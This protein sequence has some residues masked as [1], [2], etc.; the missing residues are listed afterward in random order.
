[1]EQARGLGGILN[2][3]F[4]CSYLS[5][6]LILVTEVTYLQKQSMDH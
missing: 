6:S 3:W 4:D 5:W 1:M 2:G